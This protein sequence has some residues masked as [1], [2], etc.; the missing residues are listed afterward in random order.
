M[1]KPSTLKLVAFSLLPLAVLLSS[2]ELVIRAFELDQPAILAGGS[3]TGST[4]VQ[5]DIHLGWSLKPNS[6]GDAGWGKRAVINSIGLR[7]PEIG[8][9]KPGEFRILSLG[10]STTFGTNVKNDETY[11]TQLQEILSAQL[12]S[13]PIS[14]I[15]AGVSAYSSYQSLKYLERRGLALK[16]DVVLFYHEVNDYLPSSIRDTKLNEVGVLRTDKQLYDSGLA[17]VDAVIR[18]HSALY[19]LLSR[20]Y[21]NFRI[22]R[23]DLEDFKNPVRKIGLPPE[24]RVSG[25]IRRIEH[26]GEPDDALDAAALGRRVSDSERLE[27]LQHLASICRENQIELI[28]IH[29]SYAHSKPHECLLTGFCRDE[30][31]RMF[32]AYP[33]LHP[34]GVARSV[35]FLDWWHPSARGHRRLAEGLAQFIEEH[36]LS[37]RQDQTVD[38]RPAH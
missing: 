38:S 22:E 26:P 9:K 20:A 10:E 27:N 7:S 1:K 15:N 14:V 19:R 34:G 8:A 32:E 23:L 2:A 21:A 29:P 16:P 12:P 13:R 35:M 18:K 4:Y 28:I 6:T 24:L 37:E 11:S 33:S 5:P 25:F 31:V 17:R 30:G 3:S 36:L